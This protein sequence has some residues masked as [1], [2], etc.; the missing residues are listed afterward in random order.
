[1][2]PK[3]F[4][5]AAAGK[6]REA[7][8]IL[9]SEAYEAHKKR[10]S[11]LTQARVDLMLD[12]VR[13]SLGRERWNVRAVARQGEAA[14]GESEIGVRDRPASLV[15]PRVKS[16][17]IKSHPQMLSVIQSSEATRSRE[18]YEWPVPDAYLSQAMGWLVGRLLPQTAASPYPADQPV[19]REL[20]L[21]R[22][23]VFQ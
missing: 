1:M 7:M 11:Q 22:L 18:P 21:Q 13:R 8:A 14:R 9:D 12:D 23:H 6:R 20:H 2:D 3:A 4:S 15:Q 17:R 10:Y 5:L 19:R 16:Q